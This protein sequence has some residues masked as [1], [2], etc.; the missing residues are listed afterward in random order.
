MAWHHVRSIILILI[1][2][3]CFG[4][5]VVYN[6]VP[7]DGGQLSCPGHG[8]ALL[9][10]ALCLLLVSVSLALWIND[11]CVAS[12]HACCV[13]ICPRGI[14][15]A[16]AAAGG[17]PVR[18]AFAAPVNN[19]SSFGGGGGGLAAAAAGGGEAEDWGASGA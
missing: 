16:G 19:G 7:C 18:P 3:V 10:M 12:M 14:G 17:G 2:L 9:L 4:A 8:Q 11:R 13:K 15:A 6:L 5:A 1:A